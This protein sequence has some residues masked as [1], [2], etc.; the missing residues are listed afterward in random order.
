M[1]RAQKQ[2]IFSGNLDVELGEALLG[3]FLHGY[4][5][6]LFQRLYKEQSTNGIRFDRNCPHLL[7]DPLLSPMDCHVMDI[8][9][10]KLK[11]LKGV[12]FGIVPNADLGGLDSNALL[13]VATENVTDYSE[14]TCT[15][16]IGGH[17]CG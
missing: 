12:H 11:P 16:G 13:E 1:H 9:L 4:N 10:A 5:S 17:P 6:C 15:G 3:L 7:N 8:D 14:Y 2:A